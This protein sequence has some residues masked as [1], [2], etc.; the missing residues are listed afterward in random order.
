MSVPEIA[1]TFSPYRCLAFA[2][3]V[4]LGAC[5]SSQP[6]QQAAPAAAPAP[7]APVADAAQTKS[8]AL[9]R[10]LLQGEQWELAAPI[11][12]EIVE[13]YP[14]S[15]AATEVQ[16]TLDDVSAKAT[17]AITKRRLTALWI[18]QSNKESGGD[19]VT[20][21][22]YSSD[23]NPAARV[24]LILRRHSQ[25]GQSAYL[26]GSGKGFECK[27]TCNLD[28][29]F[30]DTP[31][32]IAAFLPDTG[33]PAIFIK[34]DK[35]FIAKLAAAQKLTIKIVEKGKGLRTLTYEVGGYDAARFP[36]LARAKK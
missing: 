4:S 13:K 9:Y 30:D 18:Y 15:A 1:M 35:A 29:K 11:G 16:K 20:A 23:Q 19:Q 14:G 8:L 31:A 26:F 24:R 2:C 7:A 21:S 10:Q 3:S 17:A 6:P 5:S 33:E 12:K 25:W 36:Q 28:A 22:I 27:G 34:D 32:K